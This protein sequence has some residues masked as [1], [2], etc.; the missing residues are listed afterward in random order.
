MGTESRSLV[1]SECEGGERGEKVTKEEHEDNL[2]TRYVHPLITVTALMMCTYMSKHQIIHYKL[3]T[4]NSMS[5][6]LL[7]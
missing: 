4:V 1:V 7:K 3:D 6:N 5:I 2:E